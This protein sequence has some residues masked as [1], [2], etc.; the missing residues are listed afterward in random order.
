M[1]ISTPELGIASNDAVQGYLALRET[2]AA[3]NKRTGSLNVEAVASSHWLP[4]D[5]KWGIRFGAPVL[6][7]PVPGARS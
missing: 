7:L 6:V 3:R 1:K 5:R 4:A 2:G